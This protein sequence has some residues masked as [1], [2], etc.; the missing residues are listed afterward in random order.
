ME[1]DSYQGMTWWSR[2]YVDP[3]NN[4]YANDRS[5]QKKTPGA[6]SDKPLFNLYLHFE[7]NCHLMQKKQKKTQRAGPFNRRGPFKFENTCKEA[8]WR[9]FGRTCTVYTR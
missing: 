1:D 8:R 7:G 5:A 4:G 6:S 2:L 3:Y 9:E